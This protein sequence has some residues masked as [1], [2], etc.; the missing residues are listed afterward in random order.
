MSYSNKID[1]IKIQALLNEGN[2][3]KEVATKLKYNPHTIY[4]AIGAG[5]IT[6]PE[7]YQRKD[8]S[9]VLQYDLNGNFLNEYPTIKNAMDETGVKNISSTLFNGRHFSGGYNWYYKNK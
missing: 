1:E 4:D 7:N 2:S 6:Y 9:P 8:W 5:K 3:V